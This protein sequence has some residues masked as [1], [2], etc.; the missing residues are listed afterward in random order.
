MLRSFGHGANI[1]AVMPK[2]P[3]TTS[4]LLF[5]GLRALTS[6]AVAQAA[7][8]R[9]A[10]H[11]SAPFVGLAEGLFDGEVPFA[12]LKRH[13]DLGLGDGSV[14]ALPDSQSTPFAIA[15][16][17]YPRVDRTEMDQI[18]GRIPLGETPRQK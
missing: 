9:G 8:T 1:P 14:V 5:C 13:G 2:S 17:D 10:L 15:A 12:E 18:L 11:L 4:T 6:A 3:R 7:E 16:F